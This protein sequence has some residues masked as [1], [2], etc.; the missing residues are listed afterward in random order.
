MSDVKS[1]GLALDALAYVTRLYDELTTENGAPPLGTQ[2]QVVDFICADPG[3]AEY[4]RDW[5]RRANPHEARLEPPER[6]PQDDA[7]W[8]IRAELERDLAEKA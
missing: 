6:P 2:N 8:T 3:L 4:V 7:Y 1:P 5:A